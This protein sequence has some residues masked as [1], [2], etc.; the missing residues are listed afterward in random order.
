[1]GITILSVTLTWFKVL[2]ADFL[3]IAFNKAVKICE[4]LKSYNFLI[5]A[6]MFPCKKT[7][8]HAVIFLC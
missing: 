2:W 1:M 5:T 4:T 8:T 3:Q 7:K 6:F